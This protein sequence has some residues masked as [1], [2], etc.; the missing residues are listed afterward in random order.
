[1]EALQ[2]KRQRKREN[3]FLFRAV[4]VGFRFSRIRYFLFGVDVISIVRFFAIVGVI[5]VFF[6]VRFFK[7]V[8]AVDLTIFQYA[9]DNGVVRTGERAMHTYDALLAE[10]YFFVSV[11]VLC[12]FDV[13][14]GSGLC[15]ISAR[16]ASIGGF[17]I[18]AYGVRA[19]VFY[20]QYPRHQSAESGVARQF[21]SAV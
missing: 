4:L 18:F 2:R 21:A 16:G 17:E 6:S 12:K 7:R 20:A 1:M 9:R 8:R 19:G 15:A 3:L 13:T 10:L 5:V 14:D 11:A